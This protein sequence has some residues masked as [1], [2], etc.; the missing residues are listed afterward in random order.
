METLEVGTL[1]A[2]TLAAVFRK[3]QDLPLLSCT[4]FL[5][6]DLSLPL[7]MTM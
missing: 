4:C 2:V 5:Q 3:V 1:V 7:I 6:L